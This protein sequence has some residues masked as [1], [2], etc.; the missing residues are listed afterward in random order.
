VI[1]TAVRDPYRSWTGIENAIFLAIVEKV[2]G[3]AETNQEASHANRLRSRFDE[4]IT[5][6]LDG[7]RM[8]VAGE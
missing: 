1:G 6:Q 3:T 7:F 5:G 4:P 8:V 2:E